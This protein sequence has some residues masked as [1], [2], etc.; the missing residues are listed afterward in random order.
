MIVAYRR[1][2]A[3]MKRRMDGN[4]S[5][6]QLRPGDV[7]L[8]TRG[9]DSYWAWSQTIEVIHVNLDQATLGGICEQMYDREITDITLNDTLDAADP[10]LFQTAMML[11]EEASAAPHPGTQLL[12]DSLTCQIGVHML[13]RHASVRFREP[14]RNEGLSSAQLQRV[15]DYV[16]EHLAES[17][18]LEDLAAQ[19]SL[20][21]YHFARRFRESTGLSPHAF[22]LRERVDAAKLLLTRSARP[23][24]EIAGDCGFADQSHLNRVFRQRTGATPGA[25]RGRGL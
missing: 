7:S 12:I 24:R 13:R 16:R 17:L 20:S 9:A 5:H 21:R 14:V 23:I 8:L 10:L 4:W 18:T 2:S 11:A 22:V 1:G 3:D 15:T 6:A 19:V 25:Y